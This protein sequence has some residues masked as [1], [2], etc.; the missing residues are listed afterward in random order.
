MSMKRIHIILKDNVEE[1]MRK[2]RIRRKGDISR[3]IENL[4][5]EDLK[6]K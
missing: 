6:I 4:I 1:S 3:Y 2:K 5:K